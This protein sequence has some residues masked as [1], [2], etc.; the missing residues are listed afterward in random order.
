MT[1]NS[2]KPLKWMKVWLDDNARKTA[3]LSTTEYGA[4]MLMERDY[5]TSGPPNDDDNMLARITGLSVAEWRRIRPAIEPLFVVA[6]GQWISPQIDADME[7]MYSAI[8]KSRARVA[9]ATKARWPKANR[10]GIRNGERNGIRYGE[11]DGILD[12]SDD[13]YQDFKGANQRPLAK[14][15]SVSAPVATGSDRNHAAGDSL[16]GWEDCHVY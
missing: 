11:R 4:Y 16:P 2:T 8:K 1:A 12:V 13:G 14:Q 9:A 6:G 3:R 7:V 10:N 5:W 15:E